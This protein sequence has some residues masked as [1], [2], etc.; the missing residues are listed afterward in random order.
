MALVWFT[1]MEHI[2]AAAMRAIKVG[3][4]HEYPLT[5]FGRYQVYETFYFYFRDLW[6]VFSLFVLELILT[7]HLFFY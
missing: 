6:A 7:H 5:L 2:F 1:K 4:P 3:F